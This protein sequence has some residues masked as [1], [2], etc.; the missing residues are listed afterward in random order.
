MSRSVVVT[1]DKF[2][3]RLDEEMRQ[4]ADSVGEGLRPVVEAAGDTGVDECRANALQKF[5]GSGRYAKG[6][7]RKVKGDGA[8]VTC[9]VGNASLPGLVHLLEKGHATVGGGRVEGRPHVAPAAERS[10]EML[11]KGIDELV[12]RVLG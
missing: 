12:G 3:V 4:I 8:N 5:K 7:R 11:E 6:F 1:P 10:F 2:A 9:E